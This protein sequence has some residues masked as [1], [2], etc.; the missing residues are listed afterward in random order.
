MARYFKSEY[1][2]NSIKQLR[3]EYYETDKLL[4]VLYCHK[5]FHDK[6]YS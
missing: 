1:Y 6:D 2:R 3:S 4:T 5:H